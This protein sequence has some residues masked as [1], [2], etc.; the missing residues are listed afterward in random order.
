M[1][2]PARIVFIMGA[3]CCLLSP[4]LGAGKAAKLPPSRHLVLENGFEAI[5]IPNRGAPLVTSVV[6]VR[7]GVVH[8]TQALNGIS[9]MLEHLLW[10]GTIRRTQEQIYDEQDRYG[11]INNA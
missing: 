5:L 4:V 3:L 10:N 2:K 6:V 9:H 11:F 7:A 1:S 8:E